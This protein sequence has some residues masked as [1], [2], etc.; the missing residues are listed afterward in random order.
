MVQNFLP[1]TLN[2]L[3]DTEMILL[4]WMQEIKSSVLCMNICKTSVLVFF[5]YSA[6]YTPYNF[7]KWWIPKGF[8]LMFAFK[9]YDYCSEEGAEKKYP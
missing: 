6:K 2:I 1:I 3:N 9:V 8:Q 5:P 7:K 4:H